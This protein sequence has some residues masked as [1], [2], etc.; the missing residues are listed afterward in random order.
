MSVN[1]VLA[2]VVVFVMAGLIIPAVASSSAKMTRHKL[3]TCQNQELKP[4][5]SMKHELKGG[6]KHTFSLTLKAKDLLR[7]VVDQQGIDVVVRLVGLDGK[8]VQETDNPNGTQGAEPLSFIAAQGGTYRVEI[9]SLKKTD[10]AGKYELKIE[11]IQTATDQDF[12]QVEIEKLDKQSEYL[13]RA[14]KYDQA[15]LLAHRP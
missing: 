4:P 6:E 2:M 11:A 12:A 3:V 13:H 8:P 9:E 7:L 14:G 15:L 1:K 10:Q 5:I